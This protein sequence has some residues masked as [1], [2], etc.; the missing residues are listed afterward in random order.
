MNATTGLLAAKVWDQAHV[1][2]EATELAHQLGT[3]SAE[4]TRVSQWPT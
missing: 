3:E 4:I 1:V 2:V